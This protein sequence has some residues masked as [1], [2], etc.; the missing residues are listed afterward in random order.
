MKLPKI[1]LIIALL[2]SIKSNA[3][4]DYSDSWEDF[5]SYNNVKDFFIDSDKLYAV[6][7]NAIFIY[8]TNTQRYKKISSINGLSGDETSS[9]FFSNTT[10]RIVIGYK[11]GVLEIIN[12]D[13]SIRTDKSIDNLAITGSKRINHIIQYQD[14]LY[15][16]TPFAIIEYDIE[17][18]EFGDTFYIGNASSTV[19]IHQLSVIN[20]TLYAATEN[21]IYYADIT[22]SNLIDFNNWE[23]PQGNLLGDF[24]AIKTF[25]NRLFTSKEKKLYEITS[26]NNL[27]EKKIYSN[28]I[29]NLN[30]SNSIL[31]VT[32]SKS[33]YSYNQQ[34]QQTS[35][36]QAT[37]S[38]NFT[39]NN[40]LLFF[41][42]L[43]LAT[44]KKGVLLKGNN[45][46]EFEEIHPEGPLFNSAYSL[47][48]LNDNLWVVFGGQKFSTFNTLGIKK[49]ISHYDGV[50][51]VNIPFTFD[52][53]LDLLDI[54]IDP[55][56]EKKIFVSS[57]QGG[58][59]EL[60]D[61]EF[62]KRY[63]GT[64]S[65][66]ENRPDTSICYISSSAFDMDDNLW[67]ANG[68][69]S[70][71]IKKFDTVN[72]WEG[73]NFNDVT[74]NT[75]T[76]GLGDV[77]VDNN[78]NKLIET[79]SN[80]VLILNKD[81]TKTKALNAN[82]NTGNLPNNKVKSIA[83]DKSN[84]IW[85]GTL[86]GLV[87]FDNMSNIFELSNYQA[88]PIIIKLEGGTDENQGQKLLG[89]QPI[90]AITVDGAD[91]KWF[92][93]QSG[94][95][96]GTNPSGQKT[97]FIFNKENS[98]LPSNEVT[99]IV[100]DDTTGKVYFATSKG[101]VAFNNNV[102]PYG[103]SLE[104]TYAYPNPS[105]KENE[106][107]TIDGR[108]GTHLPKRTN[109]KILDS[110][111]YLVYETNVTEGIEIKGGK[112]TWNK[113]NLAGRKV[114]SGIYIIMLTLPDKSETSITK[115]AIIN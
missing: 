12:P 107:I 33:S 110:A 64:N 56:D 27:T 62:I 18:L 34:L 39:L 108:H 50:Q 48:V 43:Y 10:K 79:R 52:T 44:E 45:Q 76:E 75:S 77:I 72:S 4:I 41:D 30:S 67:V 85:I 102:S 82:S 37:D 14:K 106:F 58:L 47:E 46:N 5:F 35:L 32:L 91:N 24:S 15:L 19:N 51:W 25:N 98:P 66:L 7:D 95:V 114:A 103:D 59:V 101:I 86:E 63:K 74:I 80:G 69:V 87:R 65:G 21:G 8:N 53:S 16:A 97:L 40:S 89:E 100:V 31:T 96:L 6:C 60:Y 54:T 3:Q 36:T 94:G 78:N 84:R 28:N 109:V 2:I 61:N 90:T 92:G 55:N 112:V 99:D 1:F 70:D 68:Y 57:W 42:N 11:T 22:N 26:L 111:G 105:T 88:E 73:Y 71:K 9:I 93:T 23:Q 113:T 20:D 29:V 17:N 104:E 83:V 13:G 49:G 38:F 81:G 115:V